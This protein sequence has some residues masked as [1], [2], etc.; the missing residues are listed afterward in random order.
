MSA[1]KVLVATL[2]IFGAGFAAGGFWTKRSLSGFP[3][4]AFARTNAPVQPV[5][6][7]TRQRN[8]LVRRMEKQLEL[9]SAQHE[10]IETIIRESHDRTEP[11]MNEAGLKMRAEL[12][13][14]REQIR[15]ELT[16]EQ[17]QKF[18]EL[19]RPRPRKQL[20]DGSEPRRRPAGSTNTTTRSRRAA[21]IQR[22]D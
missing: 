15:A 10:R 11:V 4:V 8:E 20:D 5:F 3:E 21:P 7:I 13:S 22:S 1:W 2:V 17:Q 9:S 14:V 6:S 19:M 12:K 18:D 16:P